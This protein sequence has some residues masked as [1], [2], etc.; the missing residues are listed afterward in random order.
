MSTVESLK[1]KMYVE[2]PIRVMSYDTDYMQIVNNTVYGRWFE[3]LRTAIL[4]V[5]FPLEEML[6]EQN[7]PILSETYIKYKRPLTIHDKP[8][9]KAWIS[10]LNNSRWVAQFEIVE[11]DTLFCEGKQEGYYFNMNK[12]RPVRFPKDLLEEYEQM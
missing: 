3:D 7:T 12:K 9:G 11:G 4:D 2:K 8:V 10:E 1:R 6:K 5:Y